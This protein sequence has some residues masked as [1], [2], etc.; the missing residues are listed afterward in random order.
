MGI[1]NTSSPTGGF[2]PAGSLPVSWGGRT[3]KAPRVAES[4]LPGQAEAPG[5][6]LGSGGALSA[7]G[8]IASARERTV[9][10]G[11]PSARE[12]PL[13][14]ER[15]PEEEHDVGASTSAGEL[16]QVEAQEVRKLEARDRKVRAH[17]Q[18]HLAAAG[19]YARSGARY[20]YQEGP[21][22]RRY[23]VGGEVSID[24]SPVP[25]DARATIRKAQIVRRAALA[26]AEP[27]PQDR[28]VAAEA[29]AMENRARQEVSR[30]RIEAMRGDRT[31]VPWGGR[32]RGM[33]DSGD[34]S[35]AV[36]QAVSESRF[37]PFGVTAGGVARLKRYSPPA[38]AS[39]G[40]LF[41][42]TA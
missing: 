13:A 14:G 11:G 31:S 28:R 6:D 24:A 32:R 18:A 4:R 36:S 3:G 25:G 17:E 2:V 42:L 35:V 23:A 10:G 26:P 38:K 22:R 5:G 1:G 12:G 40:S 27:S 16:T 21:D 39:V 20:E 30:E 15:L 37:S 41:D 33:D 7:A 34:G 29:S 9:A 8:G 19:P